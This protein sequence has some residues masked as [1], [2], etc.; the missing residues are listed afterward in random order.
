MF[1]EIVQPSIVGIEELLM[2]LFGNMT[3]S[4]NDSFKAPQ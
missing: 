2:G 3:Y 1:I 4:I